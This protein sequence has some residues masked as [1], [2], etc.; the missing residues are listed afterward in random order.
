MSAKPAYQ[1]NL[2]RRS[3]SVQMH[4]GATRSRR[5]AEGA[6][7]QWYARYRTIRFSKLGN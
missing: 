3:L 6:R 4:C 7:G 5:F 2:K 1:I